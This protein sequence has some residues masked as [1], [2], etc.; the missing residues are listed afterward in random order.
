MNTDADPESEETPVRFHMIVRTVSKLGEQYSNEQVVQGIKWRV[1]LMK[2][3]DNLSVYLY[4]NEKDIADSSWKVGCKFQLI[5]AGKEQPELK[6]FTDIT[7]SKDKLSWGFETFMKWTEFIDEKK[8][9]VVNDTAF[10]AFELNVK[11]A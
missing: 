11:K 4:A 5:S 8:E 9:H 7:F 3:D 6:Q 1:R 10:F 2:Q